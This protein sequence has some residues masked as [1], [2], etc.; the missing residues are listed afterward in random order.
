MSPEALNDGVDE[1]SLIRTRD[2]LK[3]NALEWSKGCSTFCLS[4]PEDK[5]S[6]RL[7]LAVG[8][9][10]LVLRWRHPEEWYS[11][12]DDTAAGFEFAAELYASDGPVTSLTLL[13]SRREDTDQYCRVI[14][15]TRHHFEVLEGGGGGGGG[16]RGY[17]RGNGGASFKLMT[18]P[19]G[20]DGAVSAIQVREFLL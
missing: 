9:K 10:V 19:H 5:G 15:G 17:L 4:R 14:V 3:E 20:S 11:L 7:A 2:D 12:T 13:G 16:G 1:V 6:L 8:R 18:F